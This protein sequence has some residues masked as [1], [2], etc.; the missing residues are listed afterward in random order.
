ML[1]LEESED[2]P[3]SAR[4]CAT[5]QDGDT[6][7]LLSESSIGR[8]NGECSSLLRIIR[9]ES[10]VASILVARLQDKKEQN[11]M[12][13]RQAQRDLTTKQEKEGQANCILV[14]LRAERENILA[15]MNNLKKR[16][17]EL[18]EELKNTEKNISHL[19][20]ESLRL[21][22][23]VDEQ[24]RITD[25]VKT[26]RQKASEACCSLKRKFTEY[27]E[28]LSDICFPSEGQIAKKES[29]DDA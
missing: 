5:L 17:E 9:Q 28:A 20:E 14:Q 13:L 16:R 23:S 19:Q 1:S 25:T 6:C 11:R 21:Q 18:M 29:I 24:V 22:S 3:E 12:E 10:D 26:E 7:S 4:S 8:E 15:Q 27:S 2:V